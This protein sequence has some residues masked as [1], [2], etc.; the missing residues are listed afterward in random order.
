MCLA[1][2]KKKEMRTEDTED[3]IGYLADV[4]E[5]EYLHLEAEA[6]VHQQQHQVRHLQQGQFVWNTQ[7]VS[8]QHQV[9]HLQQSHLVWNTILPIVSIQIVSIQS[10]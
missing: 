10:D 4:E 3:G 2:V 5:L 7:I 6:G 8:I 9:R 1:S